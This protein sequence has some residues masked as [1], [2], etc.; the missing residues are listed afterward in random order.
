MD[1]KNFAWI[2]PALT[3]AGVV[4][5]FMWFARYP[6]LR[7][8]PWV[9]L[10]VVILGVVLSFLGV[11]AV[12]AAKRP[13]SRKL[14]AAA[15]LVLAGALAT[16]FV[17]YVF[18]LSSMLPDARQETMAMAAAP[19]AALTDAGGAVVDLSDYRGRKAVL[20]FYRGYW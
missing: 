10:P 16:L 2:G 19:S 6:L 7:D 17:G 12:F 18:V 14:A 1:K 8:F 9:N 15:G 13:W 20:V 3:F 5:Y 4:T 11:M